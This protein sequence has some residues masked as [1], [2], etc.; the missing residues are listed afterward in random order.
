LNP[1]T[2]A[3]LALAQSDAVTTRLDR[4][5]PPTLATCMQA[6]LY[7]GRCQAVSHRQISNIVSLPLLCLYVFFFHATVLLMLLIPTSSLID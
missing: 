7:S 4:S 2:A 5:H 6:E 3:T 1:R